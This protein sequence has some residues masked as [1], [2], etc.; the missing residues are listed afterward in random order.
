MAAVSPEDRERYE[1]FGYVG[2]RSEPS[3]LPA[4]TVNPIDKHDV[5]ERYRRAVNLLATDDLK[6][7]IDQ[8]KALSAQ[9]SAMRDVWMLLATTASRADHAEIALMPTSTPS[10]SSRRTL[11]LIWAPQQLSSV[12]GN[13]TMRRCVRNMWPTIQ[14][15]MWVCRPKV[16]NC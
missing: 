2:A 9:E 7:A 5:V 1:I 10:A 16:M 12:S 13:S 3:A 15:S 11:T 6:G 8:F 4:R 14:R